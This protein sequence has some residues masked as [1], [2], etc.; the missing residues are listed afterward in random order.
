MNLGNRWRVWTTLLIA[1][2]V[3]AGCSRD[4]NVLKKKHFDRGEAYFQQGKYPEAAI[5]FQNAIQFDSKFS[6]AHYELAQTYLKQNEWSRAYQ[7]LMR[8]VQIAP[9]NS[10]AQLDL[11]NLLLAAGKIPEARDRAQTLLKA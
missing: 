9:D 7:E 5:E 6:Q 1:T 4:P 2:S 3:V 8:T 11:A 10:K